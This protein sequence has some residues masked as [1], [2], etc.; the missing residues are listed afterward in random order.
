MKKTLLFLG[1]TLAL[2]A[3]AFALS[4]EILYRFLIH[5]EVKVPAGFGKFM[6]GG[7]EPP[8]DKDSHFRRNR[9][10][11]EEYGYER[12]Y[13][14]N[15]RG[16][17]VV[18][19]LVKPEKESKVY[20]FCSHGY[21]NEGRRE[22]CWFYKHYVEELGYNMFIV[23]HQC[24]GESEGEYVGFSSFESRDSM[25]WLGYMTETF[26]EDIDIILHGISMGSATVMLMTGNDKLPGNV[27]FTIADCGFTSALDEFK[28]KLRSWGAPEFPLVPI[29]CGMNKRR[30][31]YDFQTDTNALEAVAKAE[32]PMLFIH[33]GADNFVP[34]YMVNE[35]FDACAAPYKDKLIVDGAGHGE[36]YYIDKV[37]YEKKIDEFI[38]KFIK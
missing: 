21:R 25:Q 34:T 13:M 31:G 23:D 33:G 26:G 19:Y 12:H 2:G 5:K 27:R 22:W 28:F 18:G 15:E 32:I 37:T 16:H 6:S 38:E 1:G 9:L 14:T 11:L 29:I 3:G 35:L 7:A 17:K 4:N 24:A 36:S 10:A 30:A 20:V 8:A